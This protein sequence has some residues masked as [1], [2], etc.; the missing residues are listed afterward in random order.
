MQKI[1]ENGYRLQSSMAST[2]ARSDTRS[3]DNDIL[4]DNTYKD[5][6]IT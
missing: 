1:I 2:E 4:E 5:K 3:Y 6:S